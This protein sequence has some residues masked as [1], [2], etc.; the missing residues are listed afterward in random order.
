VMERVEHAHHDLNG[1]QD[2]K[3]RRHDAASM[4]TAD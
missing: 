1:D 3:Q 4:N 2:P